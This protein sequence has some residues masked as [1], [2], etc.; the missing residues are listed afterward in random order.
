MPS[1]PPLTLANTYTLIVESGNLTDPNLR[2]RN[3]WDIHATVEP[4]PSDAIISDLINFHLYNLRA[5]AG[6]FLLTL[7]NWS[8]GPQPFASRPFLWEYNAGG[9]AGLKT[10]APPHGYGGEAAGNQSIP[11]SAVLFAKRLTS[12]QNKNTNL[13]LRG[14]LDDADIAAE[15]GGKYVFATGGRVTPG[16]FHA[17][18]S[19]VLTPYMG[20]SPNPGLVLVHVGNHGA[21]PA[22][23]SPV[24]DVQGIA[25]SQ[26]KQTRKNKR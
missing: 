9:V 18:V 4:Q 20:A 12:G 5:D 21:G 10:G 16:T 7:R 25:P 17:V 26:N 19:A 3:T 14:L 11:G 15:T 22:F 8:Q 23:S 1:K 24:V 13:F 6:V 2:W